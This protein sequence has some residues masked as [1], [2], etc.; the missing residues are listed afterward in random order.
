MLVALLFPDVQDPRVNVLPDDVTD[1]R[2]QGTTVARKP[3]LL[4]S[5]DFG[6]PAPPV[7]YCYAVSDSF[8]ADL[9]RRIRSRR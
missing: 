9:L 6:A 5:R 3:Y 7:E 4:V 2:M 8:K 1:A